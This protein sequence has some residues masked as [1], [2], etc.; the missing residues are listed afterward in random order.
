MSKFIYDLILSIYFIKFKVFLIIIACWTGDPNKRPTVQQIV[1]SLKSIISPQENNEE[2]NSII[3]AEIKKTNPISLS[4]DDD[5]DLVI[6]DFIKDYNLD[7]ENEIPPY[8]LKQ[9]EK[10][11]R[12]M[13]DL[14]DDTNIVIDKLIVL[15]IRI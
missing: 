13:F 4:I 6:G 5:I 15:L 12:K 1:L 9:A 3:H 11:F 14:T 8:I 7:E 10:L 2:I